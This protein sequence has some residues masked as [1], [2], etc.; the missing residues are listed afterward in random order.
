ML[1]ESGGRTRPH[2]ARPNAETNVE[3]TIQRIDGTDRQ[4]LALRSYLRSKDSLAS[5]W[6]W[7]QAEIDAYGR[8]DQY[9]D[10]M[11]EIDKI[12]SRFERANP[13]FTLYA[14][15]DVRSLD[16]QIERWNENA[17]VGEIA[18][19]LYRASCDY[20]A[21]SMGKRAAGTADRFRDFLVQWQ[22]ELPAPL[23]APGLSL[24]GRA[25]AIDFQVHKDDQMIAGT[26]TAEIA[27]T[28]VGQG[29]A[30]K[31]NEAV[32]AA[33]GK[34]QGPLTLPDEPWHYEYR[35]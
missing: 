21:A 20:L 35:P 28:W 15:T 8:S 3:S 17:T 2:V 16:L 1:P 32:R 29:W 30:Q 7:S 10:M 24:H 18:H 14:N 34:F 11:A 33:S 4:L 6:S 13:G 22:P 23:A 31:L 9:R 5:R 27:R 26:D 19:S 25:R 12:K